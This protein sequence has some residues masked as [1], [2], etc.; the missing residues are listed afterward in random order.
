MSIRKKPSTIAIVEPHWRGHHST[1]PAV[2]IDALSDRGWACVLVSSDEAL[3][4]GAHR[5]LVAKRPDLLTV[6]GGGKPPV[7]AS[8]SAL[9]LVNYQLHYWLYLRE[10]F[11][12]WQMVVDAIYCVNFDDFDKAYAVLGSPFGAVPVHGM[13]MHP[14]FHHRSIGVNGPC[15]RSDFIYTLMFRRMLRH[16]L[17]GTVF[18][19]DETLVDFSRLRYGVL[20]EKVCYVPDPVVLGVP[21]DHDESA[22]NR[23]GIPDE[24][25]V[26]LLFGA[27]SARKGLG[28]AVESCLRACSDTP[29]HLVVAG[30]PDD[31][32]KAILSGRAADELRR[33][34]RLT[35]ILEYVDE[36]VERDLYQTADLVWVAYE[37]FWSMSGVMLTAHA[38]GKPVLGCDVGLIGAFLRKHRSGIPIVPGDP[39]Q[40]EAQLR[41]AMV[42][43]E[44]LLAMG[45]RGE[46]AVAEH[47]PAR[48]SSLIIDRIAGCLA[49]SVASGIR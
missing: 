23:L 27:L 34:G 49:E 20:S 48:F 31:S 46:M 25:F 21:A 9:V 44:S 1:Y 36:P 16:A 13:L 39:L 42:N 4:N 32:A 35:E 10:L 37:N 6:A 40:I 45:A 11:R 26:V 8:D 28:T 22:R 14:R 38:F 12:P 5:S 33:A 24:A 43:S 3:R 17:L 19:I 29:I 18:T 15:T 41:W 7:A 30:Y 47:T 2:L